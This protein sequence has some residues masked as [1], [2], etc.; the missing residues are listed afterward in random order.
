M[1]RCL[2]PGHN[3]PGRA[4]NLGV[5]GFEN[6]ITLRKNPVKKTKHYEGRHETTRQT[7]RSGGAL[8]RT[9]RAGI[10]G[11]SWGIGR[12]GDT[13]AGK[14]LNRS[15]GEMLRMGAHIEAEWAKG[16]REKRTWRD[17]MGTT[18][19]RCRRRLPTHTSRCK[20]HSTPACRR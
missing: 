7:D 19:Y 9:S 4:R 10:R 5:S 6:S 15:N 3:L 8:S 17:G 11:A 18:A 20:R 13:Q 14:C 16:Q 2:R 1:R 12:N